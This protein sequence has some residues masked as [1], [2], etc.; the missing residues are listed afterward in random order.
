MNLN[1]FNTP[2]LWSW[3]RF[4]L[5]GKYY[6]YNIIYI[7]G[8][9]L[10]IHTC[11]PRQLCSCAVYFFGQKYYTWQI[12]ILGFLLYS[13]S[14]ITHVLTLKNLLLGNVYLFPSSFRWFVKSRVHEV[15]HVAII[16]ATFVTECLHCGLAREIETAIH[17]KLRNV[18]THFLHFGKWGRCRKSNVIKCCCINFE[19]KININNCTCAYRSPW[20]ALTATC[21]QP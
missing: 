21:A 5:T 1:L 20:L 16:R 9:F 10:C 11:N 18:V 19:S 8:T 7:V 12:W 3:T 13:W 14:K 2:H 4:K 6:S 17:I 15:F